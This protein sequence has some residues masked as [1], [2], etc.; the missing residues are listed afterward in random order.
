MI[1]DLSADWAQK[2]KNMLKN[3]LLINQHVEQFKICYL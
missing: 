2:L 1:N 3:F